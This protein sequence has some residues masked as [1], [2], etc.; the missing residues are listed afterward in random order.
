MAGTRARLR[1]T[2]L[3]AMV[4]AV[5][6]G[7][8]AAPDLASADDDPVFVIADLDSRGPATPFAVRVAS[9]EETIPVDVSWEVV[10]A[11]TPDAAPLLTGSADDVPANQVPPLGANDVLTHGTRYLYRGTFEA[12]V[13]SGHVMGKA[14]T[15]FAWDSTVSATR[16][17]LDTRD[18]YRKQTIRD[19]G[20]FFPERDPR[21]FRYWRDEVNVV[22]LQEPGDEAVR[23]DELTVRNTAGAVVRNITDRSR[24]TKWNG[25]RLNGDLVPEGV[26]AVEATISDLAGNT[27][28]L[29]SEVQVSHE[30][31]QQ[32]TWQRTV[33]PK[34]Y[35]TDRFV[36][37]CASLKIPARAAWRGS[38]GLRSSTSGRR[39]RDLQSQT[40]S[41]IYGM[42]LP[43]TP[44]GDADLYEQV[45]VATYGGGTPGTGH[46]YLVHWYWS[47]GQ[48][49][50]ARS[51][52][53]KRLRWHAGQPV[54]SNVVHGDPDK[55]N[56]YIFWSAG[57]A[58][59]AK[60]DVKSFK[61][62][63]QY[64]DVR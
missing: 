14:T 55:E 47:T 19:A 11:S 51:Q 39:C 24:A 30:R 36:G 2:A 23:I 40:A 26:Y 3:V 15:R 7:L 34:R 20:V 61:V 21:G 46:S 56:P 52:F 37:R 8:T 58:E 6:G 22:V 44:L 10:P 32:A 54:G 38:I 45:R 4:A 63:I 29:D 25:R 12:E 35:L 50:I 42:T 43:R 1:A 62:T 49:W 59:G 13:G 48:E 60:Y 64:W 53:D 31:I 27:T 28:V 41:T 57:L 5:L 9:G 16:I 17:R 33:A 18:T